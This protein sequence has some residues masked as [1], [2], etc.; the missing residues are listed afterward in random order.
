MSVRV[1]YHG[2]PSGAHPSKDG[3]TYTDSVDEEAN[4]A[5]ADS[6]E[7]LAQRN[8]T[9]EQAASRL[10]ACPEAHYLDHQNIHR[11]T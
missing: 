6:F 10:R 11:P 2:Y 3:N 4:I 5:Q 8:I 9:P 7:L 1:L